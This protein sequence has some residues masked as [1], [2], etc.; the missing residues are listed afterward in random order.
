MQENYWKE[1]NHILME[2]SYTLKCKDGSPGEQE[3]QLQYPRFS[4]HMQVKTVSFAG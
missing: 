4:C 2:K 3:K 1:D